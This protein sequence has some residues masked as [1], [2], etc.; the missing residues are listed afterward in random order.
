MW[1]PWSLPSSFQNYETVHFC[2]LRHSV[3]GILLWNPRKLISHFHHFSKHS[4]THTTHS[5]TLNF[6]FPLFHSSR[7]LMSTHLV[8]WHI[9]RVWLD[10]HNW[11][12]PCYVL[13]KLYLKNVKQVHLHLLE[14]ATPAADSPA[15]RD[16]RTCTR[17]TWERLMF[18]FPEHVSILAGPSVFQR[19]SQV[20]L[21]VKNLP[22]MQETQETWFDPWLGKIPWRRK[23]QSNPVFFMISLD[24][25]A[26]QATL[27]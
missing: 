21:A 13:L 2:C 22:T 17:H 10:H 26:W 9:S 4:Y 8:K 7:T 5:L 12:I 3:H 18:L 15:L 20:A 23:W 19:A 14:A 27:L 25:G 16:T 6:I 11:R 1:P 24:R